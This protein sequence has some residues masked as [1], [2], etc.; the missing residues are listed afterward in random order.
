GAGGVAA[1]AEAFGVCGGEG[2]PVSPSPIPADTR[3][4][5][6]CWSPPGFARGRSRLTPGDSGPAG[7]RGRRSTPSG[8][9]SPAPGRSRSSDGRSSPGASA[10]RRRFFYQLLGRLEDLHLPRPPAERPL[11]LPDPLVGLPELAGR[12]DVF[13]RGDRA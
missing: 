9:R 11:E 3:M 8:A 2:P 5:H 7:A 10:Q 1:R 6:G 4:W 13:V 12:D